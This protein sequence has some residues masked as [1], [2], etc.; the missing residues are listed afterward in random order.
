MRIE[1]S[2]FVV[3]GGGSGLGLATARSLRD[4][5]ARVGV[6]DLRQGEWDG[7]FATAD[8][9]DEAAV[10]LA[11]NALVGEIGQLRA[12]LNTTGRAHDRIRTGRA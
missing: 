11:L 4:A 10:K 7:A 8:V 6:L 12:L 9:A 5:G 1:G 3:A 2:G